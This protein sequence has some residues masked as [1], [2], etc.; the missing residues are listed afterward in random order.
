VAGRG[1]RRKGDDEVDEE[2]ERAGDL[3][4]SGGGLRGLSLTGPCAGWRGGLLA[5]R[6][7]RGRSD[8]SEA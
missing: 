6:M 2:D 5:R 1:F 8:E 4:D 7:E 3:L